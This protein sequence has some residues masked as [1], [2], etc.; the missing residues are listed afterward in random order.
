MTAQICVQFFGGFG[1]IPPFFRSY[2][3][4]ATLLGYWGGGGGGHICN[5]NNISNSLL[6]TVAGK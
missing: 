5:N 4:L 1:S 6:F 3:N 2:K